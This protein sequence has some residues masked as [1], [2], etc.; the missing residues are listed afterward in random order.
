LSLRVRRQAFIILA[1]ILSTLSC[2]PP[3]NP[4]IPPNTVIWAWERPE[5]LRFLDPNRHAVAF[6]AQTLIVQSDDVIFQPRRQPIQFSPG[7]YLIAV[8]RIETS[9]DSEKRPGLS[10]N[11]RKSIVDYLKKSIELPN[12]KAVQIDFDAVTSEREFYRELITETRNA[13]DPN[14][15]LTI[16]ALTSWCLGDRWLE[17][18]SVDDAVPMLFDIGPSRKEVTDLLERGDDFNE[19]K[20][21]NSYG[22]SVNEPPIKGVKKDRRIY[23]FKSA[24]WTPN[25]LNTINKAH[26]N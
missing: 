12:V 3:D 7:T 21:R 1:F 22:V 26:E 10:Q 17:G 8:T 24:A 2:T 23:L 4:N 14:I 15:S 18:L 5:D 13:I 25:D 16:T 11:Q 9:R 6:L 19:P 20:C